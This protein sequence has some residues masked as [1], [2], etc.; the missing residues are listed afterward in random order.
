MTPDTLTF[1]LRLLDQVTLA[2]GA[3]TFEAEAAACIRARRELL[4]A[5]STDRHDD[6]ST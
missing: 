3:P 4:D 6:L 1:L 2:V 5:L